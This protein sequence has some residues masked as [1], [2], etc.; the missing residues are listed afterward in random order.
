MIRFTNNMLVRKE[1]TTGNEM[2]DQLGT[3]YMLP[4]EY[5]IPKGTRK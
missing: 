2:L 5:A 1:Q 3:L 4:R